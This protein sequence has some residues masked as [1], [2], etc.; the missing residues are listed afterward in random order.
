MCILL[1]KIITFPLKRINGIIFAGAIRAINKGNQSY[2][3][4]K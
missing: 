4:F 1:F 3:L 2:K